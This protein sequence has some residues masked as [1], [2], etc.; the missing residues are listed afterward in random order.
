MNVSS[1][2]P[3]STTALVADF[4]SVPPPDAPPEETLRARARRLHGESPLLDGHNDLPFQLRKLGF[5]EVDLRQEQTRVHTDI[6]RLRAGGVGG[7]FWAAYPNSRLSKE[8]ALIH[9]L[10]AFD[11][12]YQMLDTYPG[13]SGTG[14]DG[15]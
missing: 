1:F 14:L 3:A 2:S 9:T 6:T 4:P 7:V 8:T 12:I 5:S 11:I 15:G 10:E 13:G